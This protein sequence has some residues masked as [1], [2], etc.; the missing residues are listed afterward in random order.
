MSFEIIQN[1]GSILSRLHLSFSQ[2]KIGCFPGRIRSHLTV[3]LPKLTSNF[4]SFLAS[5][6]HV[7]L[8][9]RRSKYYHMVA[10]SSMRQYLFLCHVRI[11]KIGLRPGIIHTNCPYTRKEVLQFRVSLLPTWPTGYFWL[12]LQSPSA[13]NASQ[14][15]RH[16][17]VGN[18]FAHQRS[19][20]HRKP[21][22]PFLHTRL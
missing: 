8:G 14:R 11:T 12:V 17:L 16:V 9:Y 10:M 15:P 22:A 13:S 6:K 20:T 21:N 2:R 5:A 19:C 1:S 4:N 18:S 3:S 7:G